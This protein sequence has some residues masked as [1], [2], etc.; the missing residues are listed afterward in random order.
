MAKNDEAKPFLLKDLLLSDPSKLWPWPRIESQDS[1]KTLLGWEVQDSS[2]KVRW[3]YALCTILSTC[4]R[5]Q[6]L[7]HIGTHGARPVSFAS[8]MLSSADS[9]ANAKE[10]LLQWQPTCRPDSGSCVKKGASFFASAT[11]KSPCLDSQPTQSTVPHRRRMAAC[12]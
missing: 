7:T 8:N 2:T 12:C 3:T 1:T 9:M 4:I 5:I 10:I 11:L 6:T